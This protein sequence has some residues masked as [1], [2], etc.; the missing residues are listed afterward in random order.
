VFAVIKHVLKAYSEAVRLGTFDQAGF[1]QIEVDVRCAFFGRFALEDA[2]G[3][4][5]FAPL[6]ASRRVS[7]AIPFGSPLSYRFTL[8][9]LRPN[10]EGAYAWACG[11]E[12]C[13]VL[14]LCER[15]LLLPLLL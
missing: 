7:N 4:H 2:I 1:Q 14:V 5:A 13:T 11:V 8:C 15:A 10:A 9:K 6:E 12:T 3:S